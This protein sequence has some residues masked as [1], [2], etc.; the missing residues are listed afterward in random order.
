MNITKIVAVIISLLLI[1]STSTVV[2]ADTDRGLY[3]IYYSEVGT[4]YLTD[5]DKPAYILLSVSSSPDAT[6]KLLDKLDMF[7][8]VTEFINVPGC[9]YVDIAD[10]FY[11]YTNK[12]MKIDVL[13][14]DPITDKEIWKGS[15]EDGS[16]LYLGTDNPNGYKIYLKNHNNNY[17]WAQLIMLDNVTWKSPK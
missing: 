3:T 1:I 5:P 16:I 4:A 7:C 17:P 2:F 14:K 15:L 13:L 11:R 8:N 6:A 10:K 9:E 12:G